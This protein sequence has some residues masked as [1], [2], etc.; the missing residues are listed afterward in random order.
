MLLEFG[1][2]N[3]CSFKEGA[4]ISFKLTPSCPPHITKGKSYTPILGIKGKNASGKTNILKALSFLQSFCTQSFSNKP[5]EEIGIDSYFSNK[6][7]S[8]FYIEFSIKKVTYIYELVVNSKC[9]KRETLFRKE[10]RKTKIIERKN[11]KFTYVISEF[12][13]LEQIKL[14][15][16][17]SFIDTFKQYDFDELSNLIPIYDFFC[18]I[19]TNVGLLGMHSSEIEVGVVCKYLYLNKDVLE[20]VKNIIISFDNGIE[21][22]EIFVT[23][24]KETQK[25]RY[26]P[27]FTHKVDGEEKSMTFYEE[28]SGTKSLFLQLAKYNIVL[29]VGGVLSLD[30]FDI[31]FHPHILPHLLDLFENEETN[32]K[33]A[34]FIFTTHNTEILDHLSKYRTYIVDKEKN[35]SYAYRL[36]E[37]PGDLI[38]NDRSII[39]VY[40]SGKIGGVPNLRKI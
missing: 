6:D 7:D 24:D 37:I 30:E 22:I 9:T 31:A 15:D 39:P 2:K 4:D 21:D 18:Y 5:E 14:R 33:Q 8:E 13:A 11:N 17:A 23:K 10:S 3:M 29:E 36:D 34:Q 32:P 35:E 20:F 25:D 26:F 12:S 40:N 19:V 38:R 28:S 1:F 16:N 27:I